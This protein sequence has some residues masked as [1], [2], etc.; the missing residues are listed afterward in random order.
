MFFLGPLLEGLHTSPDLEADAKKKLI[1]RPMD[2]S[3]RFSKRAT[4]TLGNKKRVS[5]YIEA[6]PP[7]GESVTKKTFH[8]SDRSSRSAFG[9]LDTQERSVWSSSRCR[10]GSRTTCVI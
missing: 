4:N 3:M 1:I 8:M 9:H 10:G 7:L 5:K 2:N 6:V